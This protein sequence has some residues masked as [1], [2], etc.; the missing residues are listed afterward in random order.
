MW[1]I[2]VVFGADVLAVLLTVVRTFVYSARSFTNFFACRGLTFV[3]RCGS[4]QST[5]EIASLTPLTSSRGLSVTLSPYVR[6]DFSGFKLNQST[7]S[8]D[9]GH[10]DCPGLAI[11]EGGD[12]ENVRRSIFR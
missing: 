5:A 1:P 9:I 8:L 12:G 4:F 2:F 10:L 6:K 3:S 7:P 11:N